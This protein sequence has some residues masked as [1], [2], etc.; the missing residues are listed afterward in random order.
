MIGQGK[1]K[2]DSYTSSDYDEDNDSWSNGYDV[3]SIRSIQEVQVLGEGCSR[4]Y[5]EE[6]HLNKIVVHQEH[7]ILKEGMFQEPEFIAN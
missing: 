5:R 3:A 6:E 7:P 2:K 1:S 4:A